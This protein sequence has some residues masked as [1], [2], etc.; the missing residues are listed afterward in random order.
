MK[1]NFLASFK[2]PSTVSGKSSS[3]KKGLE[4]TT[5]DVFKSKAYAFKDNVVKPKDYSS[6]SKK[7]P[8]IVTYVKNRELHYTKLDASGSSS[9]ETLEGFLLDAAYR[10][11]ALDNAQQYLMSYG[12]R[13]DKENFYDVFLISA[14]TVETNL[15]PLLFNTEYI[16]YVIPE[17]LL[18]K[19][20]YEQGVLDSN[21][22]DCFIYIGDDEAY[23][24]V[25]N[26]GN[27]SFVR[28]LGR[29][30]LNYL[31]AQY[32]AITGQKIEK[33][34]FFAKLK[35]DGVSGEMVN[36]VDELLYFVSDV[37]ANLSDLSTANISKIFI[38]TDIGTINGL[39]DLASKRIG[40]EC[41]DFSFNLNF[42]GG[43][44]DINFLNVLMFLY[45]RG[46]DDERS[47]ANLSPYLR[48]PAFMKRDGGKFVALMGVA[49][50]A[51]LIMP[52]V[53][54]VQAGLNTM[55]RDKQKLKVESL[56]QEVNGLNSKKENTQ[57]EFNAIKDKLA[58]LRADLELKE[59]IIKDSHSKKVEYKMKNSTLYDIAKYLND[60]GVNTEN[61][62]IDSDNIITVVLNS[63]NDIKI[64]KLIKF[65][66]NSD[67]Y[68]VVAK[69]ISV[70]EGIY[71]SAIKI[72]VK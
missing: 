35:Q 26:Q 49:L 44:Q 54:L 2:G 6:I 59:N 1:N 9:G 53:E 13:Q 8:M 5:V 25:Y 65:I 34:D 68:S 39:A 72:G 64:T 16:D 21:T 7:D 71:Q 11:L 32:P 63:S 10:N 36:V 50:V 43:E 67:R 56:Q 38:G 29:Y 20:L 30:T 31:A 15:Q 37:F 61:I 55:E 69:E 28:S 48:P 19:G 23:V 60:Q 22:V 45:A 70:K 4:I 12:P 66:E 57:K 42:E 41:R 33:A 24:V 14:E 47:P 52:G 46:C 18:Y 40:I 58:N 51:G 27:F 17:P 3:S 62:S